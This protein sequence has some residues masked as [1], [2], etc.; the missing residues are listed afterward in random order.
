MP[1]AR[2]RS[3]SHRS[4]VSR[5]KAIHSPS[6]DQAAPNSVSGVD[7]RSVRS[8]SPSTT[9][10]SYLP[11]LAPEQTNRPS[12]DGAAYSHQPSPIRRWSEPSAAIDHSC[13]WPGLSRWLEYT[14]RPSVDQVGAQLRSSG[15]R[16]RLRRPVPSTRITQMSASSLS[17]RGLTR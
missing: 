10:R 17:A 13:G 15:D 3:S 7:V 5:P 2:I 14:M 11:P 9:T 1:S 6:G 12:G 16:V 4:P 8:P